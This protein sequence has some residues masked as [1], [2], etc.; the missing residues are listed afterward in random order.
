[1]ALPPLVVSRAPSI[2]LFTTL[3]AGLAFF[4]YSQW[5]KPSLISGPLPSAIP[6]GYIGRARFA[7]HDCQ[8]IHVTETL[9]LKHQ[10]H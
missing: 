6:K 1:M 4:V 9:N 5:K 2:L 7:K 3:E 8:P 10:T